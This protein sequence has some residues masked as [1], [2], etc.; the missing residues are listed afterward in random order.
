VSRAR[1]NADDPLRR[2]CPA[3]GA[4]AG[5]GCKDNAIKEGSRLSLIPRATRLVHA[6]RLEEGAADAPS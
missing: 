5:A 3:C 6:A 2:A 1:K 4:A